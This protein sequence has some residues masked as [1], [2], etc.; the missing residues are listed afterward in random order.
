MGWLEAANALQ[1]LLAAGLSE[2]GFA[3]PAVKTYVGWPITDVVLKDI[4]TKPTGTNAHVGIFTEPDSENTS[5]YIIDP[6]IVV[7]DPTAIWSDFASNIKELSG[8]VEAGDNY[9]IVIN[10]VAYGYTAQVG[11]GVEEV[12]AALVALI[13]SPD[14][15]IVD[16]SSGGQALLGYSSGTT[17]IFRISWII[18]NTGSVKE[19]RSLISRNLL[20]TIWA[21]DAATREKL[22]DEAISLISGAEF[23]TATDGCKIRILFDNDGVTDHAM[24]SGILRQD[25]AAMVEYPIVKVT[26]V[27]RVAILVATLK[28]LCI[29]EVEADR[30]YTLATPSLGANVQAHS[31]IHEAPVGTKPGTTFTLTAIPKHGTVQLWH[32]LI[33]Q[34]EIFAGS[35]GL[36]EFK[37]AGNVITTGNT[38]GAT[39][40]FTARYEI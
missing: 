28:P 4:R 6:Q 9:F 7:A 40:A 13:P 15:N 35:P 12:V 1:Q 33:P 11:D 39:D 19:L 16:L 18:S 31:H 8:T 3:P 17:V 27:A 22:A 32:N 38:I 37:M 24:P 20:I 10:D 14:F 21:S 34:L 5:R 26:E 25:I 29:A 30:V 23:L 36:N 2:V